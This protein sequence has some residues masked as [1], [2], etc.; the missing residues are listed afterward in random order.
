M[1]MSIVKPLS[2]LPAPAAR[3]LLVGWSPTGDVKHIVDSCVEY[4]SSLR[5]V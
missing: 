4:T 2:I 3:Q 1:R 5:V